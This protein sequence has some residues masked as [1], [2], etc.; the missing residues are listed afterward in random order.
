MLEPDPF[1][2]VLLHHTIGIGAPASL[3][4][5]TGLDLQLDGQWHRF[6]V[7]A[8][9]R[10]LLLQLGTV[11]DIDGSISLAEILSSSMRNKRCLALPL[12]NLSFTRD[13]SSRASMLDGLNGTFELSMA[14]DRMPNKVINNHILSWRCRRSLSP[15]AANTQ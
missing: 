13:G 4:L 1:N 14:S 5:T 2:P 3:A 15:F 12:R 7:R 6:N 9:M 10:G 11:I 8:A